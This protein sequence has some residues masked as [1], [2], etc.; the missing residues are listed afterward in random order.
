ML[1]VKNCQAAGYPL[2]PGS[3]GQWPRRTPAFLAPQQPQPF[4]LA[5]LYR[6]IGGNDDEAD[7]AL[8]KQL[9]SPAQVDHAGACVV[10]PKGSADGDYATQPEP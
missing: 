7:P 3:P 5:F 1:P 10:L 8:S 4:A 9:L 2:E 6:P